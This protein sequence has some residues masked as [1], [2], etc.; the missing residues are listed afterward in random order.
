MNARSLWKS[1]TEFFAEEGPDE[2]RYDPIHLT[3]VLVACQ[4][5]VGILFWLLWTA[6]V[7][8]GGFGTGE[9]AL[10]NAVA[11]II[12]AAIIEALRRADRRQARKPK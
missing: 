8:E 11:L 1:W 2:P 9:G 6:M 3:V 12:L 5:A 7:Y 10:G 4:A